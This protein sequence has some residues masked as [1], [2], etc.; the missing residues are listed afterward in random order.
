VDDRIEPRVHPVDDRDRGL[1]DFAGGDI[2]IADMRGERQS[3]GC[4]VEPDEI[5]RDRGHAVSSLAVLGRRR[6]PR[7]VPHGRHPRPPE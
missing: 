1:Q 2:A 4:G 6:A 7:M 3:V 5:V